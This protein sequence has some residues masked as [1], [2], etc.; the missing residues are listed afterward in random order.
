M[1]IIFSHHIAAE[2]EDKC[3]SYGEKFANYGKKKDI[4][5]T[6]L[7][8]PVQQN[9]CKSDSLWWSLKYQDP[10]SIVTNT[11]MM[12][13]RMTVMELYFCTVAWWREQGVKVG[14]IINSSLGNQ[15]MYQHGRIYVG[16]E[17]NVSKLLVRVVKKIILDKPERLPGL[18]DMM[19]A[20]SKSGNEMNQSRIFFL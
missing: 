10:M 8:A 3:C 6:A 11:V 19:E 4:S 1:R 2:V 14:L 20:V 13:F 9:K 15:I 5:S 17:T 16:T 7:V 12:P 18:Q